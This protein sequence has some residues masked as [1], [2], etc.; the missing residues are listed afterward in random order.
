MLRALTFRRCTYTISP[1]LRCLASRQKHTLPDLPYDYGALEPHVGA[2]I[3]Q[4]HHSK[5]HATYVNNLNV[6]EEKY[7]ESLA[8]GDVSTQVFLQP[9][10]RFNGG[11]HIN[12]SI[13]WTNLSPNGGGEPSGELMAAIKRDFGTF[14]KL[15][16]KMSTI[17]VGVQG[18]GWGWLGYNKD[19][20]RL[21]LAAC[22][23]QDPL[24]GTTGLIPLLGIDVWEHAYYLQYKNVRPDYVKAIW[25]II[26]WENVA[27][28]FNA[29]KK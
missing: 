9:A 4:L 6:T 23:N 28:R 19:A 29:A 24:Q 1:V 3:M 25:N 7:A 11:G 8:K 20:G 15:K 2:E 22:P 13:F 10:L 17:S 16:E 14:E 27:Q 26:N 12:H 21:Q 18:S 5:H